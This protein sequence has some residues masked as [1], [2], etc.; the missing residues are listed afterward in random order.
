MR[1]ERKVIAIDRI[2]L[3]EGQLDWLPKNPRQKTLSRTRALLVSA[4]PK[5]RKRP[6]RARRTTSTKK[7]TASSSVA[8]PATSGSLETTGSY[9]GTPPTWK[10]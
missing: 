9:A 1:K 4:A 8:N 10:S 6:R 3:N 2:Q 5:A 7:R